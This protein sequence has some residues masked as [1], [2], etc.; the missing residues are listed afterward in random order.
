VGIE[1]LP[2]VPMRR[3]LAALPPEARKRALQRLTDLHF[4][5][6]DLPH[7]FV[8]P[9]GGAIGIVCPAVAPAAADP[10]VPAPMPGNAPVLMDAPPALSSRPEAAKAIFLDFRGGRV[11]HTQWNAQIGAPP[12]YECRP[13]DLDGQEGTFSAGEQLAIRQIWERVAEDYAP[14]DVNVTT[15]EPTI[16]VESAQVLITRDVDSAGLPLPGQGQAG[17]IAFIDVF[18]RTE[19][20]PAFVYFNALRSQEDYIAEAA[21]HEAGHNLGLSHDGT[22]A[23]REY[24][25]G[26]AGTASATSWA[27]IMGVGY[28]RQ[29]TQW[30]RGEYAAANNVEDDLAQ[31]GSWLAVRVDDHGDDAATA[32]DLEDSGGALTAMG[33]ITEAGDR[34]ALTFSAGAGPATFTVAPFASTE[35]TAGGN[36]DVRIE[37]RD[38][39]GAVVATSAPS[40]S[41][42]ASISQ[43][44]AA[45]DYVLVIGSDGEP[46]PPATGYTA[47]GSL[48]QWSFAGTVAQPAPLATVAVTDAKA[49]EVGLDPG[50]F[51]ISLSR[52]LASGSVTIPYALAGNA[53]AGS[54][55]VAPSGS[56]TITAPETSAI[57]TIAPLADAEHEF[58]ETVILS[59][60]AGPGYRVRSGASAMLK[61]GDP[62]L[63]VRHQDDCGIGSGFSVLILLAASLGQLAAA[64]LRRR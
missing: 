2:D 55:Y 60:E 54:D 41:T 42:S 21:A 37:L 4:S 27:P 12:A 39:Q 47:Y 64:R 28:D 9:D 57:V 35:H 3:Q 19:F 6:H 53:V 1:Q 16:A 62:Q 63:K 11:A 40:G 46:S 34:D 10:T 15:V 23:P 59:L 50:T 13:F 45:G 8:S 22:T 48:G 5:G 32:T 29:I 52:P 7:L 33:V 25:D 56:V 24:Y 61:I 38:A 49:S 30:S 51:T 17:G 31:I 36:L 14:W 26:H 18:G 20:K 43:V 44:L 58:P